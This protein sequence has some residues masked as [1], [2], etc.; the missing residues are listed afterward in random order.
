MASVILCNGEFPRKEYPLWLLRSAE[1]IICCDSPSAVSKLEKMG[2]SPSLIVGDMDSATPAL[3]KKWSDR[4]VRIEEQDDNDLAK[5]MRV[6]L[7]RWPDET[8]IHI[9]GATGKSEAHS[10]GNMGWLMEWE[11][12]HSFQAR[13]IAVDMV[14]DYGTAFA[15]SADIEL[16]VGEG[17]KVS[18]FTSDPT[19]QLHSE[20]LHWPLDGVVFDSWRKGSLNR[21]DAD[22]VALKFSHR[23]PLL[24]ILD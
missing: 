15:V 18:F 7:E 8:E 4:I 1:R 24:I 3:L 13:G 16:E 22:T 9:L 12:A 21:A 23:A 20:G 14:S 10:L 17:R 11:M 19:L 5:A 6:L 2:L